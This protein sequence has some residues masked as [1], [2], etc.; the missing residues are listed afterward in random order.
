M[1]LNASRIANQM[2][3]A[4]QIDPREFNAEKFKDPVEHVLIHF[5]QGDSYLI[6]NSTLSATAIEKEMNL[7]QDWKPEWD[8]I[9][10][11]VYTTL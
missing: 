7:D 5:S 10:G 11:M 9:N 8:R 3:D 6:V 2:I 1:A 4:F